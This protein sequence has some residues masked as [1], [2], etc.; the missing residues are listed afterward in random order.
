MMK[1]EEGKERLPGQQHLLFDRNG[2]IN[3]CLNAE[4]WVMLVGDGALDVPQIHNDFEL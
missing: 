1:N 3:F 2:A 4:N